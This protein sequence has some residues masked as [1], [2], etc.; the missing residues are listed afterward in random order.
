[1]PFNLRE[2]VIRLQRERDS[3]LQREEKK[4]ALTELETLH[5]QAVQKLREYVWAPGMGTRGDC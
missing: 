5:S 1:M 4:A 2:R 3:I